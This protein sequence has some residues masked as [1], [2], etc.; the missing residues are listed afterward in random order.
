MKWIVMAMFGVLIGLLAAVGLA[1]AADGGTGSCD[2]SPATLKSTYP[3]PALPELRP[4]VD[5][6]VIPKKAKPEFVGPD[7]VEHYRIV[8]KRATAQLHSQLPPT[9]IYGYDGIYPGPTI[10]VS[11]SRKV[12]VEW[13]NALGSGPH[14]LRQVAIKPQADMPFPQDWPGTF[15]TPDPDFTPQDARI[16]TVVHLHGGTTPPGSDGYPDDAFPSGQ[17]A[18][19]TYP[20][21]PR[22]TLLWYHDHADTITRLNVEAGLAGIYI[23]RGEDERRYG[24]PSGDLELPL[25]IQDRNLALDADNRAFTGEL[26]HKLAQAGAEFYGPY[27]LV[28]GTIWPYADVEPRQYRLRLLNGSNGRFYRLKLRVDGTTTSTREFTQIGTDSGL[29]DKPVPIPAAGL[30]LAPAERADVILDLRAHAGKRVS[31]VNDYPTP[32]VPLSGDANT[33]NA[34]IHEEV[35]KFRVSDVASSPDTFRLPEAFTPYPR[36]KPS[37]AVRTRRIYLI[38]DPPGTLKI[39]GRLFHDRVEEVVTLGDTEVWEFVN[40]TSDFHPMHLHLVE[41]EVY[42]REL[43]AYRPGKSADTFIKALKAYQATPPDPMTGVKPPFTPD[44]FDLTG[45]FCKVDENE[46]GLKDTVRVGP[47][48]VTRIVVKFGPFTCTYVYHCHI[49]EHE[50]MEMMRPFLVL[51]QGIEAMGPNPGPGGNPAAAKRAMRGHGG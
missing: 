44:D 35:M 39:N 9:P 5:R 2:S 26:L 27:T 4:Y 31:L 46:Q 18:F 15:G 48:A 16:W 12:T 43:F 10:E 13:V 40:T 29:L 33:P 22:A 1:P 20:G 3:G 42:Q 23:V 50:D 36:P 21:E 34:P 51:P 28:N 25:L 45:T 49:L 37:D 14:I 30:T 47:G 17:G 7:G 32:M 38:E 11:E 19:Y 8:M 6:L 41:F 24:L